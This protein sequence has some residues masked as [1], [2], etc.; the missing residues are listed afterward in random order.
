MRWNFKVFQLDGCYQVR[1]AMENEV[2]NLDKH[3]R[4]LLEWKRFLLSI[5]SS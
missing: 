1:S 2:V 3:P 4:N 5:R